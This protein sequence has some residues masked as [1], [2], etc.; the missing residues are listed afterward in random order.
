MTTVKNLI[1]GAGPA[2]LAVAGRLRKKGIDFEV[3]EAT[4]KI[5][6]SWTNHYER[7]HLHTVKQLSHLP[8]LP[9]PD[10]YP[11]YVPRLDLVK[12]YEAYAKHFDIRPHFNEMVDQIKEENQQW[13]VTT[14]SGKV[15]LSENVVIATGCNRVPHAPTWPQQE[16]FQGKIIHS[17][18]YKS[19]KPY[20]GKNVLVIGM[21]NTGAEIVLDL[22][23]QG[24]NASISVRGEIA[25]VPRDLNGRPVQLTA[26]KLAKLPFGFGDWLGTQIR[27][28]YFGDLSKYGLRTTSMPPA[29]LLAE[30]GKTPVI[31]IG[32]IAHI[33]EGKIKV[34]PGID[35]FTTTGIQFKN[36][37]EKPF[38]VVVIAT[39]YRPRIDAFLENT[40]SLFDKNGLPKAPVGTGHQQGLYFVG[41]DNYKLGGLLG[42]IMTDS[43]TVAN[44]IQSAV[45]TEKAS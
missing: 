40:D 14:K 25:V 35:H 38:D 44:K 36:G 29:K 21:G 6:W 13:K 26:K 37:E 34:L 9:F 43:E 16:N 23:E 20:K 2:G 17:R 12:Y 1:I 8:H 39:G 5:A 19:A 31:D 10:D 28:V 4:D 11:L 32:T 45:S 33:K 30:T 27:K 24:A 18:H 15:F 41:F 7:L 42:T 22:S 3:L